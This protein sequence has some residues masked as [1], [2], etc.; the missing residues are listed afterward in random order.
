L[1]DSLLQEIIFKMAKPSSSLVLLLELEDL[2]EHMVSVQAEVGRCLARLDT[3]SAIVRA[4][5]TDSIKKRVEEIGFLDP[6]GSNGAAEGSKVISK[7]DEIICKFS[8]ESHDGILISSRPSLSKNSR[9]NVKDK[10]N[11]S[12]YSDEEATTASDSISAK[13]TSVSF[14]NYSK[15]SSSSNVNGDQSSSNMKMFTGCMV[16]MVKDICSKQGWELMGSY[17]TIEGKDGC[18]AHFYQLKVK[19][20]VNDLMTRGVGLS[21]TKAV[22]RAFKTMQNMLIGKEGE[23]VN[24][25]D[26]ESLLKVESVITSDMPPSSL[27]LSPSKNCDPVSYELGSNE[28]KYC[29]RRATKTLAVSDTV[30]GYLFGIKGK[31]IKRITKET[32]V[33]ISIGDLVEGSQDRVVKLWGEEACVEAALEMIREDLALNMNMT[34]DNLVKLTVSNDKAGAIIGDKGSNM[35]RI[36]EQTGVKLAVDNFVT[37]KQDRFVELWGE[38]ASVDKA[39]ELIKDILA[40]RKKKENL[41]TLTVSHCDA[42]AIIGTKRARINGIIADTGVNITVERFIKGNQERLVEL[43]G[44]ESSVDKALKMIKNILR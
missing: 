11:F 14:L 15:M 1:L 24:F 16:N 3:V 17:S 18:M 34:R 41:L 31:N 38:K 2:K 20:G 39:L 40:L 30:I 44:N 37:V 19:G 13:M 21:R 5:Q 7:N 4:G 6:T 27:S 29:T 25:L 9:K 42:G 26:E 23:R 28:A 10:R 33:F 8:D 12:E 43:W 22:R 35:H 32:G 36:M